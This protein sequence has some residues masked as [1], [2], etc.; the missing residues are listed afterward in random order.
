MK[1]EHYNFII[2]EFNL[3]SV[4][5]CNDAFSPYDELVGVDQLHIHNTFDGFSI[6]YLHSTSSLALINGIPTQELAEKILQCIRDTEILF[7]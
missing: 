5:L 2:N 7:L 6:I 1:K 4:H 3:T